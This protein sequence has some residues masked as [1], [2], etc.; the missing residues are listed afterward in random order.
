MYLLVE[1]LNLRSTKVSSNMIAVQWKAAISRGCGPVYYI[2][3][4]VNLASS[5]DMV[6]IVTS[7]TKAEFS[8]LANDTEYAITV[9]AVNRAS[10]GPSSMINV[11]T[12]TEDN[13]EGKS[14]SV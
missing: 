9:T 5:S 1:D 7:Q 13:G 4:A 11:T 8:D 14:C 10:T 12:L 2:V 3:S 6:T